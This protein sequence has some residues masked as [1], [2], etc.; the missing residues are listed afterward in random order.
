MHNIHIESKKTHKIY[1]IV[2]DNTRNV[3]ILNGKMH[4]ENI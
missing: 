3:R 2:Q 4:N 1:A